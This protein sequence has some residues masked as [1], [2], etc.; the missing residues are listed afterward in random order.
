[1][2]PIYTQTASGSAIAVVF[3]NIPQTFTDLKI[4]ASMRSAQA[5]TFKYIS[6]SFNADGSSV[7]S[8][9]RLVGDGSSAIS[10]RQNGDPTI[11]VNVSLPGS[12]ITS[13]TYSSMDVYIPNYTGANFKQTV[14]DAVLENNATT[15]YQ[16]ITAGLYRSTS[17]IT[18]VR[19]EVGDYGNFF[20]N[21]STFTLY[22]IT[23]G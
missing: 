4:V 6:L 5:A 21:A 22:G 11:Y 10:A 14:I 2:Q 17:P 19:L 1:M 18:S 15:G 13:N 8:S 20:T 12:S 23:K 16:Q 7:Y 9:T 3:N